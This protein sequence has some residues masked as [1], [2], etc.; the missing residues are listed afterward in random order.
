MKKITVIIT[1]AGAPGIQGTIYSLR[2]NYDQRE[3]HIIGTDTNE[4]VV[5]RYLCDEFEVISPAKESLKYLD[6][7]LKL[8][9]RKKATVILPQNTAELSILSENIGLFQEHGV[10]IAISSSDAIDLANNKFNLFD[11]AQKMNIPVAESYLIST[12]QELKEKAILLGW[13]NETFVVK[14][15]VSNGSRGVR[16]ITEK[17]DRKKAFFEEKPSSLYISLDELYSILGDQFPQLIVM[18]HLPGSEYTVDVFKHERH[19]AAI[20][21]KRLAIRSGITFAASLEKNTLLIDTSEQLAKAIGLSFCFGFQYKESK[22]GVPLLL[23]SNPRI[24]GTM[25]M[26]TLANANIIYSSVK[27]LMDEDIPDFH[28]NWETK[29]LRYWGAIGINDDGAIKI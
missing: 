26:S 25:V 17:V 24:Q 10:K 3:I 7:L 14:P 1:G 4:F 28:I 12:F 5:G 11:I 20:P 2:N 16:I 18:E 29:M 9:I 19:L 27:A 23:E 15:P 13:P 21:R 22:N 8:C 6:D